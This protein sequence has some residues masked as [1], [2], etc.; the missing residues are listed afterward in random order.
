MTNS[1]PFVS[2][3]IPPLYSQSKSLHNAF[4][5]FK[6][7]CHPL[8]LFINPEKP[9]LPVGELRLAPLVL[10]KLHLLPIDALR[11]DH[12]ISGLKRH[13][14]ILQQSGNQK[15]KIKVSV[16]LGSFRGLQGRIHFLPFLLLESACLPRLMGLSGHHCTPPPPTSVTVIRLF[17]L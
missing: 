15:S 1:F 12:K 2:V 11:R 10:R 17:C 16:G 13:R 4:V 3:T 7:L 9:G 5:I 14:F 8:F 6:W